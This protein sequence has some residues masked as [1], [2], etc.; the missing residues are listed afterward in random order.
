MSTKTLYILTII[1]LSGLAKGFSKDVDRK[2]AI[3]AAKNFYYER[4]NQKKHTDYKAIAVSSVLERKSKGKTDLYIIN[5]QPDGFVIVSGDDAAVPVTAYS[6]SG[7]IDFD[8]PAPAFMEWLDGYQKQIEEIRNLHLKATAQIDSM[9]AALK[10][11]GKGSLKIFNGKSVDPL[12]LSTWDQGGKYNALCPADQ[13]GPGGH[14]YAGCVAVAM[15]QVMYYYKYPK[16][17]HGTHSYTHQVYGSLSA[18]FGATTYK[19][20]EMANKMPNSGNF[21]IA[22]LLYH[23]GVSVNM[24][25]SPSGS[26]AWSNRC[27]TAYKTYFGYSNSVYI[28]DKA[29]Y[30][31]NQWNAKLMQ[32]LGNRIPLYYHGYPTTGN[33]AGHAFNLDGYQ[34]YGYFHFNWGWSGA[35]NGYFYLNNLNP[36][37]NDFSGGQG[38]IFN[39]VPDPSKYPYGCSPMKT[40]SSL[41]GVIFDGSGPAD[42]D[43]NSDCY[44]LIS[45]SELV[46]YIKLSFSKFSLDT[47]DYVTVYDG[48]STADSVLGNFTGQ[49]L[50]PDI[51]STGQQMLIRFK[52]N[53]S[54]T[55]EGFDASFSTKKPVF[56]Q[57]TM[58]L[59]G[60]TGV[61]S[62]GS[63]T[64][65]YNNGSF[66]KWFIDGQGAQGIKLNFSKFKTEQGK[67][68]VKIYD[69][70][71]SPS[72]LLASYSGHQIPPSVSATHGAMLIIFATSPSGSDEGWEARYYVGNVGMEEQ[73][74]ERPE[75]Y[76][77]PA[78]NT[79][80][81]KLSQTGTNN[82]KVEF[83]SLDGQKQLSK[84][85]KNKNNKL[86]ISKLASGFY[87]VKIFTGGK[88]VCEKLEVL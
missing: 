65:K 24:H 46:Q 53:G 5:M 58:T 74:A 63:D 75:I 51:K 69:P 7:K 66:C 82:C 1:I 56:C 2:T 26:G 18:N 11:E 29:S 19:W 70:T 27:V 76:P 10:P 17:G 55:D 22:Q 47:G 4:I 30:T 68:W 80:N 25:Y 62:D 12:L 50:P 86:D 41:N 43:N 79:L 52:S 71:Q 20:N 64:N 54:G 34:G 73:A 15:A 3:L 28:D 16:Q 72:V 57:G 77:N 44:W 33:G 35:Y 48:S 32:S 31:D 13:L 40:I 6:F 23:C 45:P 85:L 78:G 60:P 84:T 42:Y 39:I 81:I 8:N 21:E 38:A 61:F 87:F 14:V 49:N 36:G 88:V 37:G 83:Y 9:W 67:D 59:T